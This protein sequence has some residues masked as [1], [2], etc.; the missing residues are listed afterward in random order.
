M[1]PFCEL[2]PPL[3][4]PVLEKSSQMSSFIQDPRFLEILPQFPI[5]LPSQS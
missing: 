5:G 2:L 1:S 4:V 3:L